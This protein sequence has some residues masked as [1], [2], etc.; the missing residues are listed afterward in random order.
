MSVPL[1]EPSAA[2]AAASP[3]F[4]SN[5][6]AVSLADL[7]HTDVEP[8]VSLLELGNRPLLSDAAAD[9]DAAAGVAPTSIE[10]RD[11]V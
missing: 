9:D 1:R 6:D 5:G 7:A 2:M 4:S 10:V 11:V 8:S 3:A